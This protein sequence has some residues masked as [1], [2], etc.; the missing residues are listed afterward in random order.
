M[1]T[2][3]DT[4]GD[5]IKKYP[6]VA[7]VLSKAGLHCVGCHVSAYESLGDGCLAHGL[8]KEDIQ[9]IVKDANLKIKEFDEME[10]VVFTKDASDEINKRKSKENS[11]Y[12]R[13]MPVFDGYDFEVTNELE[14]DD[15]LLNEEF[16]VI[17]DKRTQ[18][19]LKGVTVDFSSK[20]NDFIAKR[21]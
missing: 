14:T 13:I 8:T 4:L 20:E 19:F 10:N 9:G 17:S 18:R 5:I 21:N 11:K 12:I 2:E 7:P 6:E 15:A 16:G 1:I 3:K